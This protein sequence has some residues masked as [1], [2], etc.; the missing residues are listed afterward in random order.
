[1]TL[2]RSSPTG[3]PL[4]PERV[5][6]VT[7]MGTCHMPCSTRFRADLADPGATVV[8]H[9]MSPITLPAGR[10]APPPEPPYERDS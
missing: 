7:P 3:T 10:H 2:E 5:A 9:R 6:D 8:E 4:Q 1:M